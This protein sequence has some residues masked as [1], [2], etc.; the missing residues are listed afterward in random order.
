MK[1]LHEMKGV[2]ILLAAF[3][4]ADDAIHRA[5]SPVTAATHRRDKLIEKLEMPGVK[6][7]KVTIKGK[8]RSER[9]ADKDV[10]DV[11]IVLGPHHNSGTVWKYNDEQFVNFQTM[12]GIVMSDPM[13]YVGYVMNKMEEEDRKRYPSYFYPC[14]VAY[15][16]LREA[17][18]I[19][20]I[21]VFA[22]EDGDAGGYGLLVNI[23]DVY[24]M[25]IISADDGMLLIRDSAGFDVE[26]DE[27]N[28]YAEVQ[29]MRYSP[30]AVQKMGLSATQPGLSSNT[31][32]V[33]FNSIT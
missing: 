29:F 7:P 5:I 10:K 2:Q 30:E 22:T 16:E 3:K 18:V 11:S 20:P 26:W 1:A 27:M 8:P 32:V 4:R 28:E 17:N 25:I 33:D 9:P 23:G 6:P 12:G 21:K 14:S 19:T 13:F 15:T 24:G 31:V